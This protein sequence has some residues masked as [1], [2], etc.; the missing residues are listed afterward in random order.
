MDLNLKNKVALVTG[1]ARGIGEA[2]VRLLVGE[3][4]RV[5]IVDRN[6][7]AGEA[8]VGQL[9]GGGANVLFVGADL[10]LDA[11]CQRA[12]DETLKTFGQL[13]IVVNN[14]G[15]NDG[16]SLEQ[17]PAAFMQSLQLNLFH[18]FAITHYAREALR[19]SKGA[20]INISSKVAVTGQG[21][22]SG[23][24]AAK[25]AVNALTREWAIALADDGVRVNC[26]VPAECITPQYENWF[27]SLPNPDEIKASV[28]RLVP[29]GHRMTLPEE[30]AA[31][32]VFL[33]S[34]VSAHTTGQIHF[35]DGGYTHLDRSYTSDH[36]KWG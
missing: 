17:S 24:A 19:A 34:P 28:E 8:L 14:A 35:V 11:D 6:Q 7:E 29:L 30:I 12:V 13:D 9:Q 22:T 27:K 33:A 10:T 31:A 18:V 32:V 23:Y 4:A 5:A 15:V 1:G 25:G 2:I 16:V 20:I 26:V 3:G 36:V 21:K